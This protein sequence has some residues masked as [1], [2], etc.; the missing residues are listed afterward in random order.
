MSDRVVAQIPVGPFI[1]KELEERDWT[2]ADFAAILGRPTQ[3]VSEIITGKKEITRES[4]A[5]IGA[6]L[7]MSPDYFLNLQ[8]AYLLDEQAKN[9]ATQRELNEVRRRARLNELA[10]ISILMKRGIIRGLTTDEQESEI[11][12]LFELGNIH[13]E[14]TFA[15]AARRSNTAEAISPVQLAW[16]ACVRRRARA[17]REP[18][19]FDRTGLADLARNLAN[20]LNAPRSFRGLPA[21]FAAVGVI[22]VYVE[23]LPGSRIDGC[24]FYLDGKPVI[25]LS[26]RGKRL[27]KILFTLLHEVAH[28]I[29]GHVHADE[30]IIEEVDQQSRENECEEKAN[31]QAGA[32]IL[33][34]P[35]PDAPERINQAWVSQV[36]EERGLAPIVVIGQL[37]N[38]KRLDWRTS[39]VRNAPTV[40]E[41]LASW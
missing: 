39:L 17:S 4:A 16:I 35:L 9:S 31:N 13:D 8:N 30:L 38:M 12:E 37:Q 21:L 7:G 22:L 11:K 6:A 5:Q 33:P 26:G 41:E 10:P 34:R 36:A 23:A 20:L 3:F 2:Q 15:L 27:D 1:A 29:L 40:T 32:W 28:L 14:P 24:A 25:G 19:P 18:N